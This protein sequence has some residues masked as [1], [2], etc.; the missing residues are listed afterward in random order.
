MAALWFG[1]IKLLY[2]K[3]MNIKTLKQG[4]A[5]FPRPTHSSQFSTTALLEGP[6]RLPHP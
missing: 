2:F 5:I 1:L 4:A 3:I 6:R